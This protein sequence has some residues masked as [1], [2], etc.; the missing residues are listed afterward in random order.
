[1]R[2]LEDHVRQCNYLKMHDISGS[3]KEHYSKV[4]GVNRGTILL[5]L[6]NFD[7]TKQLPQDIMH[8]LLEGIFPLHMEQLMDYVT[9]NLCLLSLADINARI[10]S[11]SYSYF[12]TKPSSLS[13]LN[14]QGSQT[15]AEFKR[16]M[17]YVLLL[18][19]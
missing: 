14:L 16:I 15:G 17:Y 3:E 7:V 11:F 18:P 8:V 4:Y 2:T 12:Q 13:S 6:N 19:Y 10:K 9:N 1:M 5:E